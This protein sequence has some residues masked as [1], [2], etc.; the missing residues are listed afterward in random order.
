MRVSFRF[1]FQLFGLNKDNPEQT[2]PEEM[3]LVKV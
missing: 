2:N 1:I 3:G